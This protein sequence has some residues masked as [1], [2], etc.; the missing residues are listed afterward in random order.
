MRWNFIF[1]APGSSVHYQ[2]CQ[3]LQEWDIHRMV[4][5]YV[6]ETLVT[7]QIIIPAFLLSMDLGWQPTLWKSQELTMQAGRWKKIFFSSEDF[8]LILSFVT[9][10]R[11][12]KK[13]IQPYNHLSVWNTWQRKY[14]NI[15]KPLMIKRIQW[16]QR[17]RYRS[18]KVW[19]ALCSLLYRTNHG[20][21]RT[22][23]TPSRRWQ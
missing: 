13:R 16:S 19:P 14:R 21:F 1:Q 17:W 6:G 23:G 15:L 3:I 12:F 8:V 5:S 20:W 4:C 11:L 9:I 18:R 10:L 22:P 7:D 2:P